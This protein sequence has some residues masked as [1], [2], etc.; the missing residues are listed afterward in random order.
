MS[1]LK[2]SSLKSRLVL[3]TL[4]SS[5]AGLLLAFTLFLIYGEH[6]LRLHKVEELQS[7]ADLIG[8][9]SAAALIFEDAAEGTKILRALQTR[10]HIRRGVLYLRDGTVLS[11]YLRTGFDGGGREPTGADGEN[12]RWGRISGHS[13]QV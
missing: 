1:I 2:N 3:L 4:V 11:S 10:N 6:L 8:T 5:S 9:N 13:E 7:A 12:V